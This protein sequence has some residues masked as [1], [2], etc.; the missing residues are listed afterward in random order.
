MGIP[1]GVQRR[2]HTRAARLSW[3]R[4]MRKP[5]A[6]GNL[7]DPVLEA[8]QITQKE[9]ADAI[10]MR[11]DHISRLKHLRYLKRGPSSSTM[12]LLKLLAK[13]PHLLQELRDV[14]S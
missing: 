5:G 1:R 9:L 10:G 3:S 2:Q 8:C 4:S 13:Y 12:A 14:T 11:F 7:V 6:P